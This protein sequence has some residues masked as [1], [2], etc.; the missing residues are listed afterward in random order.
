MNFFDACRPKY[1]PSGEKVSEVYG[2][3]TTENAG[4]GLAARDEAYKKVLKETGNARE[5]VA[6]YCAGNKWTEE[7]AKG[8]GNL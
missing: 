1:T 3:Q 7:N 8:V 2:N 5:A 6:A 4:R